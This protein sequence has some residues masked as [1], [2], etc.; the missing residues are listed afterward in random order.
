LVPVAKEDLKQRPRPPVSSIKNPAGKGFADCRMGI[1][2]WGKQN[3][4]IRSAIHDKEI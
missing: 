4:P 2:D 3:S 1:A